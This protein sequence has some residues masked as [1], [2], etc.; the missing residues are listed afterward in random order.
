MSE[1]RRRRGRRTEARLTHYEA[2]I[3]CVKTA[4]YIIDLHQPSECGRRMT[5]KSIKGRL[6]KAFVDTFHILDL[7]EMN[8]IASYKIPKT[9][10]AFVPTLEPLMKKGRIY[11]YCLNGSTLLMAESSHSS[12]V[13]DFLSKH[14]LLCGKRPC[15]SGEMRWIDGRMVFDNNSGTYEPTREHLASLR[16]SL[17]FA[18]QR[19]VIVEKIQKTRR[20]ARG[21]AKQTRKQRGGA[22]TCLAKSQT[23]GA[24][25]GEGAHGKTY[26]L[27]CD[28]RGESFC[29]VLE[30]Q[31]DT[32]D[33]VILYTL[34]GKT[35]LKDADADAFHTFLSKQSKK[36]AKVFKP[37]GYFSHKSLQEKLDEEIYFNRK[38]A[39]IY[40]EDAA[41]K[42]LTT[43]PL[44]FEGRPVMGAVFH[45]SSN[46]FYV[47]FGSKCDP[48]YKMNVKEFLTDL[49]ESLMVLQEKHYTHADIKG[50]NIVRCDD[51]YKLIDW[52]AAGRLVYSNKH[53]GSKYTNGPLRWYVA[54]HSPLAARSYL[55]LRAAVEKRTLG[56]LV[57]SR[58]L[59]QYWRILREF[60]EQLRTTTDREKLFHTFKNSFDVFS[61]GMT[62]FYAL[63]EGEADY[64]TYLPVVEALTSLKTPLDAKAALAYIRRHLRD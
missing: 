15:V 38:I 54:G 40:G 42:F 30:A 17:A 26:N 63:L 43:A 41:R 1:T 25:L 27:G 45:S 16:K 4:L 5:I 9:A 56:Y 3:L 23:G 58:Y 31:K 32:I 35:A 19:V 48:H 33:S 55:P 29:D 28:A 21:A 64:E 47:V 11:T 59:Q 44:D 36:I 60:D 13:K 39:A 52:G 22:L 51:R 8:K 18:G 34:T 37:V 20:R 24:V 46:P 50:D 10:A 6:K 62:L 12:R 14:I 2:E 49:L 7:L 57:K 53:I 61:L